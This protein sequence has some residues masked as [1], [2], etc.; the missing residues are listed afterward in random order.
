MSKTLLTLLYCAI[1]VFSYLFQTA[2][3]LNQAIK[4]MEEER[5]RGI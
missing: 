2:I 1:G 4:A 5:K 3:N